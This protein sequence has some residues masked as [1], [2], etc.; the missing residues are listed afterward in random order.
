M[1]LEVRQGAGGTAELDETAAKLDALGA[2]GA[3]AGEGAE[4]GLAGISGAGK[5]VEKTLDDAEKKSKESSGVFEK[6]FQVLSGGFTGVGRS[7]AKFG[8]PFS[9]SLVKT[10]EKLGET[11]GKA[12]SFGEK[13]AETGGVITAVGSVALVAAGAEA[14]NL[15]DKF[16]SATAQI[17][18]SAGITQAAATKI[19]DSFK[20]IKGEESANELSA[21][22]AQ[23]A[24]QLGTIQGRALTAAQA[25]QVM[26]A[27]AD[28]A[29]AKLGSLS[30][31]TSDLATVMQAYHLSASQSAAVSDDLYGVSTKT[32]V[33]L[34]TV[35]STLQRLHSQL[36]ANTPSLAQVSGLMLDLTEHGETGRAAVSGVASAFTNLL[37]QAAPAA[38]ATATVATEQQRLVTAHN[39]L[40]NAQQ[41][42]VTSGNSVANAQQSIKAIQDKINDGSLSGVEA[43]DELAAAQARLSQAQESYSATQTTVAQAQQSYAAT[44]SEV[45]AAITNTT[46]PIT[47]AQE[48]AKKLGISIYNTKGQFVGISDVISEL[49]P[50]LE[51]MT[52][53]QQNLAVQELFGAGASDKLIQ[54]ILAGPKAYDASTAAV[55]KAGAAHAAASA[56]MATLSGE[57]KQL[58]ATLENVGISAGQFLIPKL[59]EGAEVLAT[60]VGWFERNKGA[61][62]ALAGVIGGALSVA[63]GAFA[64]NKITEMVRGVGQAVTTLGKLGSAAYSAA[65]KVIGFGTAEAASGTEAEA[66]A[67]KQIALGDAEEGVGAKAAAATPEVAALDT[68]EGASAAGGAANL[69]ALGIGGL[70]TAGVGGIAALTGYGLY[71]G[72]H[73]SSISAG[74]AY[75]DSFGLVTQKQAAS[76]SM[77]SNNY[78]PTAGLNPNTNYSGLS[79][80]AGLSALAGRA[81]GGPVSGG[82]AYMVGENG[83]E[84][85]VPATSGSIISNSAFTESGS[86][87]GQPSS[88]TTNYNIQQLVVVAQNPAQMQQQLAQQA[89][90]SALSGNT[91][92][93]SNLGVGS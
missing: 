24:G 6:F 72:A 58:G 61:A 27:S 3:T 53:A 35:T 70:P 91:F 77:G 48:E 9:E 43:T 56:Q 31:T 50:K 41:R 68:A 51:K 81:S 7:A 55:T 5:D 15:G 63:V 12:S 39:S 34:D 20:N 14:V 49:Q 60:T 82:S 32:G 18:S 29:D 11:E 89:R 2:K 10:G 78:N 93:G 57:G 1:L 26:A 16:A 17:S 44:Q 66:A 90:K 71:L 79:G 28:L 80:L 92:A 74:A 40:V 25:D 64:V 76:N 67:T 37:K 65:G 85:F 13:L 88:Q 23:V 8:L 19:G 30:S 33:G 62:E 47:A 54:T 45:A 83:P 75:S 52:P 46:H 42:L 59:Q 38:T 73:P 69:G 86:G 84:P 22:Y 21:A 4:A 36:G 87:L